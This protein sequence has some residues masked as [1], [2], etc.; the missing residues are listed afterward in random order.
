MPCQ[1]SQAF[2]STTVS[3]HNKNVLLRC[4]IYVILWLVI[5]FFYF[6]AIK[7][8]CWGLR[9]YYCDVERDC[10][11]ADGNEPAGAWAISYDSVHD[12]LM[13]KN[14]NAMSVLILL[15]TEENPVSFLCCCFAKV[16][17]SHFTESNDVPAVPVYFV[18]QHVWHLRPD[19][20]RKARSLL[21]RAAT[22]PVWY[23]C[24]LSSYIVSHGQGTTWWSPPLSRSNTWPLNS[25]WNPSAHMALVF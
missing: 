9:L 12:V 2:L 6:V 18:C 15:F 22:D 25:S 5:E 8:W 16:L 11:Q 14:S 7:V 13:N 21:N 17:P 23:G 4:L 19:I 1:F 3:L 20:T 10:P 24:L